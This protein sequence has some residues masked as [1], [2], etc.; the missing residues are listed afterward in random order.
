MHRKPNLN[1]LDPTDVAAQHIIHRE[2]V[3]MRKR[4]ERRAARAGWLRVAAVISTY[5]VLAVLGIAL[6]YVIAITLLAVAGTN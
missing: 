4:Q 2:W 1:E 6:V 5:L 3:A